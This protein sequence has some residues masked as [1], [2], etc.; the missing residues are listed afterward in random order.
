MMPDHEQV[1]DGL[2]VEFYRG[3]GDGQVSQSSQ[4]SPLLFIHGAWG[5]SWMFSNYLAYL[6]A[7]GWN[8]YAMNLRG[9]YKSG[10]FQLGGMTQWDYARDV[11]RIARR[12]P[13]PPVLIGFG[14]GAHLIQLALSKGFPARGAVFISAKLPNLKPQPVPPQVYEM[15]HLLPS[16]PLPATQDI[17]PDTLN[18][19][20]SQLESAVEPRATLMALLRGEVDTKPDFVKVPYLVVNGEFD[21]SITPEK[22][23]ELATFYQGKGTL[24]IIRGVSHE[25]ILLGMEWREGANAINAWLSTNGFNNSR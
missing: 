7:A 15:P 25:G 5:G 18:W 16:Q 22:G 14:T 6:P 2:H 24:D 12:L 4:G 10:D 9:H 11:I 1:F 8:C 17:A 19:I 13:A 20:N 3:A 21:S 23:K